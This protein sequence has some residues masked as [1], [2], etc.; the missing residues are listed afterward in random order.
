[1]R[2]RLRHQIDA[3]LIQALSQVRD[4]CPDLLHC[5]FEGL[6]NIA[7]F[8]LFVAQVVLLN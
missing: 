3:N 2:F 7:R 5:Q 8:L 1:M 6:T 4:V